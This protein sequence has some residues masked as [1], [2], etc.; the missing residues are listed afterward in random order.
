MLPPGR[1][2]R[3]SHC[4]EAADNISTQAISHLPKSGFSRRGCSRRLWASVSNGPVS[5]VIPRLHHW[6]LQ[7]ESRAG[8]AIR[9]PQREPLAEHDDPAD[10]QHNQANGS[11]DW[12][13][14]LNS[15]PVDR[16]T[17]YEQTDEQSESKIVPEQTAAVV[18]S[19][20]MTPHGHATARQTSHR[21]V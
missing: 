12:P 15:P 18:A 14:E 7:L 9:A 1:A 16:D 5:V 8:G 17:A 11:D 19:G 3:L 2:V 13:A 20:T 4:I 21:R 6:F 10:P